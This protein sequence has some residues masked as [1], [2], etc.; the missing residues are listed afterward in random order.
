MD[1]RGSKMKAAK[2]LA[3]TLIKKKQLNNGEWAVVLE[4][5]LPHK[6]DE[7]VHFT[8]FVGN[9]T[10]AEHAYTAAIDLISGSISTTAIPKSA[11]CRG[12]ALESDVVVLNGDDD[13]VIGLLLLRQATLSMSAQASP[14]RA[15]YSAARDSAEAELKWRIRAAK[16]RQDYLTEAAAHFFSCRTCAE[17]GAHRCEVGELYATNLGLLPRE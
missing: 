10:L 5:D 11:E 13:T 12:R 8:L 7:A 14:H 6:V 2:A 3:E 1:F 9:E 4:G 15:I 16:N 17:D